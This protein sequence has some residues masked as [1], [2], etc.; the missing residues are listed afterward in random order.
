MESN[1]PRFSEKAD[2]YYLLSAIAA[3]QIN[4][5]KF[6]NTLDQILNNEAHLHY[7]DA[8]EINKKLKSFWRNF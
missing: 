7:N 4:N 1:D 6:N 8:Q 5:E 3:D 2:F